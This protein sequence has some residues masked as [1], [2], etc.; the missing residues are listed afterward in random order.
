MYFKSGNYNIRLHGS[1]DNEGSQESRINW[2]D[3]YILALK[4]EI[5]TLRKDK[6]LLKNKNEALEKELNLTKQKLDEVEKKLT[7]QD[8]ETLRQNTRCECHIQ[9]QHEGKLC[10]KNCVLCC[11]LWTCQKKLDFYICGPQLM[12]TLFLHAAERIPRENLRC[13]NSIEMFIKCGI[14]KQLEGGEYEWF[15][16]DESSRQSKIKEVLNTIGNMDHTVHLVGMKI[17]DAPGGGHSIL[18]D[19][20]TE[21]GNKTVKCIDPQRGEEGQ[22]SREQFKKYIDDEDIVGI[23][24]YTINLKTLEQIISEYEKIL[25]YTTSEVPLAIQTAV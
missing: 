15:D 11:I 14:I 9:L 18:C 25:H 13:E 7:K 21:K 4:E 2:K 10:A 8:L 22:M 24:F 23:K 5:L 19:V 6:V 1:M 16:D 12:L 20:S 3:E 17:P